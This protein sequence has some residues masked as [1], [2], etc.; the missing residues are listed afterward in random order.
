MQTDS[1][2]PDLKPLQETLKRCSPET[3]EAACAFRRTGDATH[4]PVVVDGVV[5]RYVEND[6]RM[7]LDQ[8]TDDL[9]LI[10]DLGLDSLTLMEIV[11]LTEDA[12]GISVSNEEL[13]QLRTLGDVRRFVVA[14][15]APKP[16]A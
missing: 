4:L 12:F 5:R 7:K 10:E 9:R 11:L 14:K 8:P 13:V 2:A 1:S 6:R 16:G 3:I 15:A